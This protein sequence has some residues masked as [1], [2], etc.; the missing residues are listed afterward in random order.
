MYLT[1]F[2]AVVV[3]AQ[4]V[5]TQPSTE[6]TATSPVPVWPPTL[7]PAASR[8][9]RATARQAGKAARAVTTSTSASPVR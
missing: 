3:F 2:S 5:W 1:P 4:V 6:P 8:M 9:A 7:C